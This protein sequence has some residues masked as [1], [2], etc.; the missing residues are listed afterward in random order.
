MF[1]YNESTL[2]ELYGEGQEVAYFEFVVK[3]IGGEKY[4]QLN[5]E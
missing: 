1:E 4:S 5:N 3:M 2:K